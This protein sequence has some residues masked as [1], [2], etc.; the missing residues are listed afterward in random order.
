MK[1]LVACEFS[2]TVRDAFKKRGHDAIS[3][4]FL[5]SEKPGKHLIANLVPF[6][7]RLCPTVS[8][9]GMVGAE[10][11]GHRNRVKSLNCKALYICFRDSGEDE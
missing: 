9:D 4:D 1:V 7:F 8:G 2:G 5:E 10:A 11:T 3:C 6:C